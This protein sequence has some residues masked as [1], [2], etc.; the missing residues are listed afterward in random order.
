MI[1]VAAVLA[2][3]YLLTVFARE[4]PFLWT[5]TGGILAASLVVAGLVA[6]LRARREAAGAPA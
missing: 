2:A 5:V 4:L 3:C 1:P 6:A